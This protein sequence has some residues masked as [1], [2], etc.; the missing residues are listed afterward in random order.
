[1]FDGRMGHDLGNG[2]VMIPSFGHVDFD[3]RQPIPSKPHL[4]NPFSLGILCMCLCVRV[5]AFV[6]AWRSSPVVHARCP[7][8]RI[9]GKP[10]VG[11]NWTDWTGASVSEYSEPPTR[12]ELLATCSCER[13]L[14]R[15]TGVGTW[16]MG[17]RA[18][19]G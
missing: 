7:A 1:M 15:S 4:V 12:V 11:R 9:A 3:S 6:C 8:Q 5:C 16:L 14:R 19:K 18:L 13:L 10:E 17:W 2:R